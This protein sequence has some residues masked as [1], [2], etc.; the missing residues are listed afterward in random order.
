MK[1]NFV[2]RSSLVALA[3]GS[4]ATFAQSY[5]TRAVNMLVPFAAGGPTDTVARV[6]AQQMSKSLGQNVVVENR[7][8]AGGILAPEQVAKASPDG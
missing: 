3:L 4:S 2:V 6:T 5:P 8:S 1:R 7:P